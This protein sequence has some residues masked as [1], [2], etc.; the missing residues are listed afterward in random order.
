M[1]PNAPPACRVATDCMRSLRDRGKKRAGQTSFRP[2]R[3]P[4]ANEQK[5]PGEGSDS[6]GTEEEEGD[7]EE[8]EGCGQGDRRFLRRQH[9]D[10]AKVSA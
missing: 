6:R 7:G 3:L 2:V 8:E 5:V 10:A 4:V 9:R 1:R